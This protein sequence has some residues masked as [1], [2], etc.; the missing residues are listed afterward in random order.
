MKQNVLEQ[1]NMHRCPKNLGLNILK[2][3]IY[4]HGVFVCTHGTVFLWGSE[5]SFQ[6]SIPSFYHVN[7]R[8]ETEVIRPGSKHFD[9][10]SHI[11]GHLNFIFYWKANWKWIIYTHMKCK[12]MGCSEKV[13]WR[14]QNLRLDKKILDVISKLWP[15]KEKKSGSIELHQNGK[16]LHC[17]CS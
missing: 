12:T 7:P 9:L 1:L 2:N 8:D 5:N 16:Q 10:L 13:V 3:Y 14:I 11:Y 6:E 15:M 4:F 17:E